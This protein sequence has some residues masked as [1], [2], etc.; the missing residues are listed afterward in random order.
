MSFE[1][2]YTDWISVDGT[3][4]TRRSIGAAYYHPLAVDPQPRYTYYLAMEVHVY[5][6]VKEATRED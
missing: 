2:V 3:D 5:V 6:M 1:P 4:A